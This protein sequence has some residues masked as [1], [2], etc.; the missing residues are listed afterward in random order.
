M[1]QAT[2]D[3]HLVIRPQGLSCRCHWPLLWLL[4]CGWVLFVTLLLEA[5]WVSICVW[6]LLLGNEPL[7]DM[8]ACGWDVFSWSERLGPGTW[9][10]DRQT[11]TD[12]GSSRG[13][14]QCMKI[15][16]GGQHLRTWH[17][18]LAPAA[19]WVAAGGRARRDWWQDS[20]S[21]EERL[22]SDRQ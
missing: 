1:S 16:D 21:W 15:L 3:S 7:R 13:G 18:A 9:W 22:K 10:F 5:S 14:S 19:C 8:V 20:A 17:G 6:L 4:L 2:S 12:R 11:E